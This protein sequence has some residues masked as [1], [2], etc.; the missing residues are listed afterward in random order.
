MH[1]TATLHVHPRDRDFIRIFEV[2]HLAKMAGCTFVISKT[3]PQRMK[4]H[5]AFDQND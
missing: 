1:T 3:K 2:H 4:A 5:P